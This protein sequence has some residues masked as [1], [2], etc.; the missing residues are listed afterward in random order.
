M[1]ELL[2]ARLGRGIVTFACAAHAM[3]AVRKVPTIAILTS[4]GDSQGARSA[5]ARDADRQ[6]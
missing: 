3:A 4:G 1:S 2:K 5:I 6:A